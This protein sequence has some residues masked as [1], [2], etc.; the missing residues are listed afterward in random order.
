[1]LDDA[2]N[3]SANNIAIEE[4]D[5]I[6]AQ[7]DDGVSFELTNDFEIE[8]DLEVDAA[9]MQMPTESKQSGSFIFQDDVD[10]LVAM[11]IITENLE[12]SEL[13]MDPVSLVEPEVIEHSSNIESE[14]FDKLVNHPFIDSTPKESSQN[15]NL[16]VFDDNQMEE[17]SPTAKANLKRSEATE[18][19]SQ[20]GTS[21]NA[22]RAC[23]CAEKASKKAEE[24]TL[25]D[26]PLKEDPPKKYT[27]VV[28]KPHIKVKN[29]SADTLSITTIRPKYLWNHSDIED[30]P[31]VNK[32]LSTAKLHQIIQKSDVD[33]DDG[34][35]NLVG[36]R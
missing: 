20:I 6:L 17:I 33:D 10:D 19:L 32:H 2:S 3:L 22:A 18:D 14:F 15:E 26:A 1:M 29:E 9:E 4:L 21:N 27:G 13:K 25:P 31:A 36:N 23:A 5:E 28:R 12:S 16:K 7:H 8:M 11:D 30:L 34:Y 35:T 24:L